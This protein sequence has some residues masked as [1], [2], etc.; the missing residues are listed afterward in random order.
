MRNTIKFPYLWHIL[1][2]G[3][4]IATTLASTPGVE[5]CRKRDAERETPQRWMPVGQWHFGICH[6]PVWLLLGVCGQKVSKCQAGGGGGG[7]GGR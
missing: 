4:V 7:G 3:I 5:G 2:P 1:W 6:N